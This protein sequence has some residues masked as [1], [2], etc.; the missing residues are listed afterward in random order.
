MPIFVDVIGDGKVYLG[1]TEHSPNS[2]WYKDARYR[3][4]NATDGTEIWTLTGWGTGMYVGQYDIL[5]DGYF[6][7]L[8]CYDMQVYSVGKGPSETTVTASP[9]VSALGSSIYCAVFRAF[10]PWRVR[11]VLSC[12]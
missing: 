5:A 6:L 1:T 12:S 3:C 8:N 4:I 2:P 9:K 10:V 11:R 7:Y